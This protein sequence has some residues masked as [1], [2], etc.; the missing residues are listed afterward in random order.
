MATAEAKR[1]KLRQA[2]AAPVPMVIVGAHD[3]L[4]AQLIDEAGFDG[5]WVSGFGVSTMTF[6]QPDLNLVT[7]TEAL[8]AARRIDA[9]TSL[10]VVADCDNGFGGYNNFVR[11]VV[12]YER[13]G[14]A[15]VCI[16]DNLFPKRNSLL[17]GDI[18]RELMPM[19]EQARR[20]RAAKDAQQTDDFVLIARVEALIAG[21]GVEE[22]CARADAYAAAGADAIL[23]HSRD[24]TLQEIESFLAEWKGLGSLPLVAVPT[25]FPTFTAEELHGKG[26]QMII[27]ANQ[28]MRAAVKAMEDTLALM[29]KHRR[30]DVVDPTIAS[31]AHVFDLVGTKEMINREAIYGQDSAE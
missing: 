22:A 31:V 4:S 7:M 25:L 27:L 21:H 2:L 20:I 23:I 6:A 5:V 19:D 8:D 13:G 17:G 15:G 29:A 30:A 3:A 24:K 12:D 1:R 16:E 26:F 10:P 11:T 18:R 14:I 28:P 9:A